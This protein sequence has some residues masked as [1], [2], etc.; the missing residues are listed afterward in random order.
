MGKIR[1]KTA[2]EGPRGTNLNTIVA[3]RLCNRV[4]QFGARV[5]RAPKHIDERVARFLTGQASPDNGSNVGV[6]KCDKTKNPSRINIC[7]FQ[8]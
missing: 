4:R 1:H 8:S 5:V 7:P 6:L 3:W 2:T